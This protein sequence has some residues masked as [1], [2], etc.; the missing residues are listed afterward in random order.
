MG[1]TVVLFLILQVRVGDVG[2]NS[3]GL[4]GGRFCSHGNMIIGHGYQGAF[5]LWK[6][7][8]PIALSSQSDQSISTNLASSMD[9]ELWSPLL[10]IGGHFDA[11]HDITWEPRNGDFLISVSTDQ[12]SRL[13]SSWRHTHKSCDYGMGV[14]S[15][16]EEG[17][18]EK[19]EVDKPSWHEIARP[20]IHGYDLRCVAMVDSL[21][22]VSGADEKVGVV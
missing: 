17:K 22:Y 2:G 5:H 16:I 6:K 15:R 1:Y 10:T 4:Y 14:G 20:Q 9:T 18:V 3:L 13:H 12:T 19:N 11:V 7:T 8:T 21:L